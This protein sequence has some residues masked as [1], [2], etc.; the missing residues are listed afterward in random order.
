MSDAAEVPVDTVPRLARGTRLSRDEARARWV[1]LAPERVLEPD[2]VAVEILQ[3]IDGKR[4]I[5]E[6]AD[7]LAAEFA[8]ER[9]EILADLQAFLAELKEKGMVEL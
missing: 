9:S 1:L 2:D 4:T 8:S 5:G 3:R 6:I 7:L